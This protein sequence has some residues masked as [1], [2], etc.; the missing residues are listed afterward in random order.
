[1]KFIDHPH[2]PALSPIKGEEAG[3]QSKS[4]FFSGGDGELEIE[5]KHS[6]NEQDYRLAAHLTTPPNLPWGCGD[7]NLGASHDGF[8]R[9][10]LAEI[11]IL[12]VT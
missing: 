3:A 1:M 7:T 11:P 8:G 10:K 2:P 5:A 4:S 12:D 6:V 9:S